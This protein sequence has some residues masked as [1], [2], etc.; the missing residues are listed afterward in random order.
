VNGRLLPGLRTVLLLGPFLAATLLFAGVVLVFSLFAKDSPLIESTIRLWSRLF[1]GTAPVH[2]QIEGRNRIDPSRQYVFAANHL[3]NYDIPVM[4][5]T[6]PVPIRFLAKK[7]LFKIPLLAQAMRRIGIIETDRQ[8]SSAAHAQI[9]QGVAAAK[10]RGHSIIV[11]P[12][13]TRSDDGILA[14]FKK[15]AFRIAIANDLPVVPVTIHG[16]WEA[17][18]P[19]SKLVYPARATATVHEP[20]PT[21][22]LTLLDIN[23]LRNRVHQAVASGL[24]IGTA[25]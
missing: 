24:P 21:S 25:G 4:L 19:G 6:A 13:G 18:P 23:D 8:A 3:S 12:E 16:T 1:L 2:L 17:W 5:L 11:F 22:E 20:I 7:E 10:D 15:G 9:N 14:E